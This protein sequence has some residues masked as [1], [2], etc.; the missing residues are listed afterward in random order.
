MLRCKGII[1]VLFF[2][3]LIGCSKEVGPSSVV[4]TSL[5]P[6]IVLFETQL[7]GIPVVVAGSQAYDFVVAF[8][9]RLHGEELQIKKSEKELPVVF[10]DEQDNLYN[11]FGEIINTADQSGRLK[12]IKSTSGFWFAISNFY[13]GVK[14]FDHP[15]EFEANPILANDPEWAIP[16][17]FVFSGAGKDGIPAINKPKYREQKP[18]DENNSGSALSKNDRVLLLSIGQVKRIYPTAILDYH[19]ILNDQIED[20]FFSLMYC[21]LTETANLWNRM[22]NGQLNSY[23]V[24]GLIYNNNLLAYDQKT[25]SIWTQI[26]ARCVHGDLLG[27]EVNY[28]PVI[29]TT[30]GVAKS[31]APSAQILSFDTGFD[32]NYAQYPY[33]DYRENQDLLLYP[34]EFKDNRLPAKEKVFLLE[35]DGEYLVFPHQIF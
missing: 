25:G 17:D 20:Q 3:F 31:M 11:V 32:R 33:G 13:P 16:K 2:L 1:L 21:P 29:Q 27:R 19:E 9:K 10:E 15:T 24:S 4:P 12:E 22:A 30:L 34:N 18:E 7:A 8:E 14:I 23:G 28:S 5:D 35:L 26:T 6:K